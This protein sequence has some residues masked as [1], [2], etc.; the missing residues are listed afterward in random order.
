MTTETQPVTTLTDAVNATLS[1]ED[2]FAADF[3]A[4]PEGDVARKAA[5]PIEDAVA[6]P[7][8]VK[9]FAQD[10]PD[11]APVAE[12]DPVATEFATTFNEEPAK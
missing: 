5:A 2:Q 12:Q 11:A 8:Y 10:E 6:D 7:A 1:P 9:A 4:S 3:E